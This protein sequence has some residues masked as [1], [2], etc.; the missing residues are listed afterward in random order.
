MN[1]LTQTLGILEKYASNL[2]KPNRPAVWRTVKFTSSLVKTYLENVQGS[3]DILKQMGYTKPVTDGLSFPDD[4]TVPDV[5]RIKV[6]AG[7][8][9]LAKY[10]VDELIH[11]RHPY[12]H[13]HT[14]FSVGGGAANSSEAAI[15]KV[16]IYYYYKSSGIHCNLYY[17]A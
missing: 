9:F 17:L 8:L 16:S 13:I 6:L 5:E 15:S 3:H 10:E 11:D 14:V 12:L 7:E 2:I 1:C 4:V